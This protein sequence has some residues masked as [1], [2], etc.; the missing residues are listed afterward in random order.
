MS[1]SLQLGSEQ[2]SDLT[3]SE[4]IKDAKRN[5]SDMTKENSCF[6]F[7][8]AKPTYVRDFTYKSL[9]FPLLALKEKRQK[10]V[11]FKIKKSDF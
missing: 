11:S 5:F 6:S 2:A 8:L 1:T 10:K 4:D 7:G 3:E 9:S